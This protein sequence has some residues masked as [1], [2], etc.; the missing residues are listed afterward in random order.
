MFR[1]LFT[2]WLQNAAKAKLRET[3]AQAAKGQST[4]TTAIQT[5]ESPKPCHLGAVFAL[6]I[7]AG[8]FEDTLQGVVKIRGSR[9]VACEGGL[10]GRRVVIMLAG[11]GQINAARATEIL[12]DG[13]KP[14]RVLSA[15]FAGALSPDLKRN[16]ILIADRVLSVEGTCWSGSSTAASTNCSTATPPSL[17]IDVPPGLSA[18]LG[19]GVHRGLLLTADAVVRLPGEKRSLFQHYEALAVDMETFAMAEVCR[20]RNVAFSSIRVI[21]DTADERLPKDVNHLLAQKTNAARLGAA[22]GA[23]CRRPASVK[24]L[25]QLKENALVASVRLAKFLGQIGF[26]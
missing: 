11:A 25:Y 23:V 2:T 9:F 6:G 13:H 7:E 20:R 18:S 8:C 24:D 1:S 14:G 4:Q 5:A 16:D 22:L 19:P 15:G 21:N 17:D 12:I 10:N 26:E 3:V